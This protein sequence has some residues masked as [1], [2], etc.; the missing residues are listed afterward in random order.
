M[1]RDEGADLFGCRQELEPNSDRLGSS[2]VPDYVVECAKTHDVS[3][4]DHGSRLHLALYG[5]GCEKDA[6]YDRALSGAIGASED[7]Q[8]SALSR[9]V[10]R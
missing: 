7:G 5:L 6:L 10:G 1:V 2:S 3:V 4:Q 8:G 9:E